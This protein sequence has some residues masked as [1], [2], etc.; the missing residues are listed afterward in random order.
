M[1]QLERPTAEPSAG[2]P[3][4]ADERAELLRLRR[5]QRDRDVHVLGPP[6]LILPRRLALSRRPLTPLAPPQELGNN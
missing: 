6:A 2:T 5:V 3:L 1:T 4:T